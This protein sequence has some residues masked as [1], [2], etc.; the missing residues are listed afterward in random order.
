MLEREKRRGS[1][2]PFPLRR[3]N[4]PYDF[5]SHV[6]NRITNEVPGINRVV[7]DISSKPPAT[8]EVSGSARFRMQASTD[9]AS[10]LSQW[11]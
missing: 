4:F 10:S 3:Y 6:S 1:D 5:L 2:A 11:L 8:I 9:T 7:L